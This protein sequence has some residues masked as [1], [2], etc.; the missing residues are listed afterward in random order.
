MPRRVV[1][2]CS[3]PS[4]AS[5]AWSR[6]MW[7]GMIRCALA[8]MRRPERSTPFARRL[9][10]LAR[11]HLRVDH[12]AVAD[13]A[14]LA[15][16]EDPGRDQVELPVHAVAHDGVPGVVA[17][18]EADHEIR[19]LREEVDD[20]ALALVAPLGAHDHDSG[21][22][23]EESTSGLTATFAAARSAGCRPPSGCRRTGPACS[24]AATGSGRL[25]C[26]SRRRSS[27]NIGSGSPHI[28]YRRETVRSPICARSSASG[29]ASHSSSGTCAGAAVLLDQVRGQDQR[30]LVLV[31]RVD[32]RVELLEHPRRWSARRRRRRCAAGRP[33]TACPSAG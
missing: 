30:A 8:L 1:P 25:N 27:P 4:F 26:F 17:A 22:V 28:S 29:R 19:L 11:Q 5:P 14:Q 24:R 31:A 12:D 7:Y 9:V 3:L 33:S 6:S 10:Q 15:G 18:L 13:R 20:L 32:D 23:V 21:H 2:I 16:I